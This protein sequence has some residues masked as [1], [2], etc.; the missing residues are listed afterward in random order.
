MKQGKKPP[1][2]KKSNQANP[3][4]FYRKSDK[5]KPSILYW[6]KVNIRAWPHVAKK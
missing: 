4:F 2:Q 5:S 3:P 6:I 1:A